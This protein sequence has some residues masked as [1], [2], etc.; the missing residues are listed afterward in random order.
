MVAAEEGRGRGTK[1]IVEKKG[2]RMEEEE[3][4]FPRTRYSNPYHA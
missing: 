2:G 3:I 4:C 1:K